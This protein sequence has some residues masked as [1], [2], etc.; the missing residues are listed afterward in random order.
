LTNSHILHGAT[1]AQVSFSRALLFKQFFWE[2]DHVQKM[3][4]QYRGR[5]VFDSPATDI[6]LI[7][8]E[9]SLDAKAL[10]FFKELARLNIHFC[11]SKKVVKKC[12]D[13]IK[14]EK[15]YTGPSAVFSFSEGRVSKSDIL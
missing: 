14:P 15:A 5:V 2:L 7:D 1:E 12:K 9:S 11:D 8:I 3:P 10:A 13:G 4:M 6:A